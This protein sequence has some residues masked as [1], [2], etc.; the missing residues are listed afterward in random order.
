VT[1]ARIWCDHCNA[2]I[3]V[4]GVLGCVRESCKSKEKAKTFTRP[5]NVQTKP[6]KL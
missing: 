5:R 2:E 3:T 4:R 1:A 6:G